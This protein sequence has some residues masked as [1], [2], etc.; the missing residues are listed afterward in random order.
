M[1]D[2]AIPGTS[3]SLKALC[4]RKDLFEGVQTVGHAVSGRTS[5]P[6]LSHLRIGSEDGRL[7]LTATDL[8]LSISLTIPATIEEPGQM[9]APAKLLSELLGSLPE[10]DVALSVDRSHAVRIRCGRSAYKLH[11]LPE[12]EYPKLPEAPDEN[13]FS[14]P[15]R[16]LRQ[17]IRQTICAA[18]TDETR[19]ILTG[20]LVALGET[21]VSLV[22]TDTHRLAL[23]EA[24]VTA[25]RGA[26]QSIVPARALNLVMRTLSDEDGDVLVRLAE[27]QAIFQTPS[28]TTYISRLIDG[29]FPNYH[30]VIPSPETLDKRLT[31]PTEPFLSAVRRAGLIARGAAHK[32]ILRTV[33]DALQ[34]TAEATTEGSAHEEVEMAREGDDIHIAFNAQYLR[35]ALEVA[36]SEGVYVEVSESLKPGIVRPAADDGDRYLCVLMPMQIA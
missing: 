6:I 21:G 32:I 9:T 8:E 19:A 27:N 2:A 30:R 25:S 28:G 17:A 31:L 35:N 22:A 18:S 34:I 24:A 23:R 7:R 10:G 16:T 36:E 5:L 15:Q 29:Q 4:V 11:G 13:S 26:Q 12:E 14:I 20:V 33:D 3:G 1:P